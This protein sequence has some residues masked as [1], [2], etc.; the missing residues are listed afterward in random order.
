[1]KLLLH[2]CCAPC[3]I[4]PL[5]ILK[6]DEHEITGC[7][8]NPNIHPSSEYQKR[9]HAL[10]DYTGQQG[11]EVLWPEGYDMEGFLRNVAFREAD[12][13]HACYYMRLSYTAEIASSRAFDGFTTTLLYSK[14]Q[15]H[16]W[17]KS[18]AESLAKKYRI[19]FYYQDFRSGWSEGVRASREKGM[20]RQ[21]Y[22]GCIYSEKDRYWRSTVEG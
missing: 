17:V 6:Q 8:Y 5:S 11:L 12:R 2:I 10:E 14:Y 21:S 19:S 20:Y 16:E 22:C 9:L 1:M 13:C 7:F 18:I 3:L 4:Y 15:K